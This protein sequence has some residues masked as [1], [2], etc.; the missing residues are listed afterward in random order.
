MKSTNKVQFEPLRTMDDFL[1]ESARYAAPNYQNLHK[2]NNRVIQNLLYYQT[3]YLCL[4]LVIFAIFAVTNFSQTIN[5]LLMLLLIIG[6]YTI[7]LMPLQRS[8]T[9]TG[10]PTIAELCCIIRDKSRH[11]MFIAAVVFALFVLYMLG[12]VL[13]MLL[14]VAFP[15]SLSFLHA[16]FR[17]RNVNNKMTNLFY[18][19]IQNTPMGILLNAFDKIVIEDLSG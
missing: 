16:S 10:S 14:M 4:T 2:W 11:H 8:N 1:W 3:N 15:I 9:G 13:N 18:Q 6:A 5:I 17:M 19:R 7:L 12:A